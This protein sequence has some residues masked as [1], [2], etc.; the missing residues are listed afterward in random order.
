MNDPHVE[1]LEYSIAHGQNIDWSDAEAATFETECFVVEVEA[2]RVLF[3]F[4]EHYD[5]EE[6]ARSAVQSYVRNWEF[7]A[8]LLCAP[9]AFNLR[10]VKPGIIDRKPDSGIIQSSHEHISVKEALSKQLRPTKYPEPPATDMIERTP[11]IDS[12]YHRY[13]GYHAGK[14]QL[15]TMAYFCLTVLQYMAGGNRQAAAKKFG[16][17]RNVLIKV[18]TLSSG[19][20]R[21]AGGIHQLRDPDNGSFLNAAIRSMIFRAAEVAHDPDAQREPITIDRIKLDAGIV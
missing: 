10:F 5:S 2:Q 8:G 11:D 19:A 1:Y 13:L 12:M 6:S 15:A 3:R 17:S 14:E 7:Q 21:K 9:D 20:E 16:I 18:G 4:R